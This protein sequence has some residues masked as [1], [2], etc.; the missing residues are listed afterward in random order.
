MPKI[1][2]YFLLVN[3]FCDV[4]QHLLETRVLIRETPRLTILRRVA[5]A[6]TAI[7]SLLFHVKT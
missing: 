4:Q 5:D 2:P 3:G 6:V 1:K 7:I